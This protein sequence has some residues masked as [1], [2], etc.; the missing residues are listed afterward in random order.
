MND[1]ESQGEVHWFDPSFTFASTEDSVPSP[2]VRI[3]EWD[4]NDDFELFDG[5]QDDMCFNE[6]DVALNRR[7]L[8]IGCPDN[9]NTS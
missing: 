5:D 3:M 4:P 7:A 2:P 1:Q 9:T 8:S 6:A